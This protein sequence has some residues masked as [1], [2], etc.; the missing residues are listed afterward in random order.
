MTAYV[1]LLFA[2]N[3]GGRKVPSGELR[4]LAIELGFGE[5][6]TVV[7][8]GNLVTTAGSTGARGPDDV[9][10]LVHDAVADRFGVDST[11]VTLTGQAL[12]AV[13][14]ACPFPGA[15]R[16][17]PA[18]LLALVGAQRVDAAGI[19]RFAESWSGTEELAV[20][21]GVLYARYPDGIGTSKLTA[22]VL[23]KAG[24]TPVTGRNWNTVLKLLALARGIEAEG[25]GAVAP[26][27]CGSLVDGTREDLRA[28]L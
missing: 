23:A 16:D 19:E 5:A 17:D 8:S 3:V 25:V 12:G 15:A 20:V 7:N 13:V 6:R 4:A 9:S 10:R 1:S 24:G 14:D 26:S 11:V 18:H 22:S 21:D 28:A 2:V 27:I